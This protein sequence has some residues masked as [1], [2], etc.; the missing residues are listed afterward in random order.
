MFVRR[1]E[2]AREVIDVIARQ[3]S[4]DPDTLGLSIYYP[5]FDGSS[6]IARRIEEWVSSSGDKAML[7]KRVRELEQE[8]LNTSFARAEIK[9]GRHD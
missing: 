6:V 7:K 2:A 8:K 3:V 5:D 9:G 1:Y 4:I